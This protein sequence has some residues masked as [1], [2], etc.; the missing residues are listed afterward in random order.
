[1]PSAICCPS[2]KRVLN[3]PAEALN[4]LVQCPACKHQFHPAEAVPAESIRAAPNRTEAGSTGPEPIPPSGP[5][6][7]SSARAADRKLPPSPPRG[8][9]PRTSYRRNKRGVQDLCPNCQAFIDAGVNVCPECGAAF[10][11]EDDAGYRP[12]EQAGLE[13]RD[14]ESHRGGLLLTMGIV[15]LVLPL[16]FFICYFGIVTSLI[17]LVLSIATIWM[18]RL[19]S[20]KMREHI[21]AREGEGLTSG[22]RVCGIIGVALNILALAGAVALV[23]LLP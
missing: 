13:R 10:E 16:F 22:A 11:S 18:S 6:A 23:T 2:C 17:G 12:W 4:S 15:S 1:M 19:D 9:E 8:Y 5:T 20:R 21:M 7:E 3:L 14:S